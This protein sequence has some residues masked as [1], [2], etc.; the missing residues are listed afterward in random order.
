MGKAKKIGS[1]I[2]ILGFIFGALMI[3]GSMESEDPTEQSVE[4]EIVK[5]ENMSFESLEKI[6]QD[7]TYK[8]ILRNIDNYKG[9]IIFVEG[10]VTGVQRDIGMLNLCVK[11]LKYSCNDFM[12]VEVN[13]IDTWLEDDKL[14]GY[15][16]VQ[17]L[18]EVFH[19]NIFTGGEQVGS[20]EY[21]PHIKE[22]KLT[23]SNC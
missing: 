22:I 23:C 7:W 16:E 18:G 13:G 5:L 11:P 6:S 2:G 20:G 9:K 4:P 21:V 15:A 12:F 14:S 3:I 17:R 10:K 1:G 19:K 8:D